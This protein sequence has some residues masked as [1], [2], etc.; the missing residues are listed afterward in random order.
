MRI[1]A[2][3]A[4]Q[5]NSIFKALQARCHCSKDKRG[6]FRLLDLLVKPSFTPSALVTLILR[7]SKIGLLFI[8]LYLEAVN[9]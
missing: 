3:L 7:T 4:V 2:F 6:I 1:L 8:Y 9:S 5:G